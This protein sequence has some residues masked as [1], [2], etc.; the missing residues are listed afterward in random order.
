MNDGEPRWRELC[1]Q[2]ALERD[3][4]KRGGMATELRQI[5]VAEQQRTS[6]RD[7][8]AL[9]RVADAIFNFLEEV[10]ALRQAA[11]GLMSCQAAAG[12]MVREDAAPRR[13]VPEPAHHTH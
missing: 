7:D 2:L 12:D 13:S 3:A 1:C 8:A 9:L 5:V 10:P 4:V 11:T 6:S